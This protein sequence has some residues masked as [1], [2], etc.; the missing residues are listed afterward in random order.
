MSWRRHLVLV[1]ALALVA[2]GSPA[3]VAAERPGAAASPA[4]RAGAPPA[5][6]RPTTK[7]PT[8]KAKKPTKKKRLTRGKATR[9]TRRSKR[10]TVSRRPRATAVR[11]KPAANMPVGWT[12]PPS[13]AMAAAGKACTDRLD[14]LGVVWEPAAALEKIAT[15]ITVPSMIFGGV[16]VSSWFRPPPFVMDCHLALALAVFGEDLHALGIRKVQFS[17]IYGFTLVRSEGRTRNVLSRHAL[18]LAM[19][20]RGITDADGREALVA[21]DYKA[22]DPLLIRFEE[23]LN[24]SGGFRMV[25]TPRNDPVSHHDHFHVEVKLEYG[26]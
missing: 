18:G 25:L 13:P 21:R 11:T 15:P 3:T 6:A 23:Y 26:P 8:K 10:A 4:Q 16:E 5:Q 12:W 20:V 22:G 24:D 9:T 17:R 14:E 19:D 1:T 2:P 7:R